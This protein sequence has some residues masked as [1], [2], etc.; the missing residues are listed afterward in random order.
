M[1][2]EYQGNGIGFNEVS[3]R[4]LVVDLKCLDLGYTLLTGKDKYDF[5]I[6]QI[7]E[8][9]DST[10]LRFGINFERTVS[11]EVRNRMISELEGIFSQRGYKVT[12]G[13]NGLRRAGG[14][15]YL[16]KEKVTREEAA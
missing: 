3:D 1:T 10:Q 14:V 13:G 6:H 15:I 16:E 9:L 8:T 5:Q 12:D 7:S 2:R 11:S 4:V